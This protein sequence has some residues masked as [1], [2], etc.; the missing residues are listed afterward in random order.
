MPATR[1]RRERAQRRPREQHPAAAPVEPR[2]TT[3]PT[4]VER[5]LARASSA[6]ASGC[7]ASAACLRAR[8]RRRASRAR[9][10]RR[11]AA[12]AA[13]ARSAPKR[14][15][16]SPI[17]SASER[18]PSSSSNSCA[19]SSREPQEAV[20]R[21]VVQH[22]A[23]LALGGV[24]AL[25]RVARAHARA[26]PELRRRR[27]PAPAP[28]AGT[29]SEAPGRTTIVRPASRCRRAAA[30][31]R[32][33]GRRSGS[34]RRRAAR[35]AR[36]RARRR[37]TSR[38]WSPRPRSAPSPL[39]AEIRACARETLGS[40]S[41]SVEPGRAP[42]RHARRRAAR[43]C[44]RRAR[45][46]AARAAPRA[47]R[48][49]CRRT[50]RPRVTWRRQAGHST[51]SAYPAAE[52][53]EAG[54]SPSGLSELLAPSGRR[55]AAAASR[56]SLELQQSSALHDHELAAVRPP[57]QLAGAHAGRLGVRRAEVVRLGEQ[58][59]G[60]PV[61]RRGD[62]RQPLAVGRERGVETPSPASRCP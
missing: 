8:P 48:R 43:A 50:A 17:R 1:E 26:H 37:R 2:R 57:G 47:A 24:E 56:R 54:L 58:Q 44:R 32:A 3:S 30:R 45:A 18:A 38:G 9:R 15:S 11:A 29:T 14:C 62:H 46:R 52:R 28:T 34:A 49:S 39:P 19:S 5:L 6:G 35:T 12:R 53:L 31:R 59:L 10:G 4:P 41:R 16:A 40:S 27:P 51:A 60:R 7:G 33:P 20:A 55:P 25:E 21:E 61:R 36:S 42:D 13:P 23:A 22:P